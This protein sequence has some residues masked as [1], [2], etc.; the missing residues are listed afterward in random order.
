MHVRRLRVQNLRVHHDRTIDFT[1]TVTLIIGQ[2]GSGK[3][4][5]IEALYI[6]LRGKSFKGVDEMIRREGKDWY[7][8]DLETDE[9]MRI[10]KHQRDGTKKTF[11]IGGKTH[12]RLVDRVKYPIVLF[13]PDDLR[14]ISGSPARRRDYLDD[15][16]SQYD[17]HYMLVL[18]RYERA[19]LQRNKLLKQPYVTSDELFAWNVA[20]SRYGTDIIIARQELVAYI[21][22]RIT[23]VYQTIAPTDDQIAIHYTYRTSPSPQHLLTELEQVY[24]RDRAIGATTVGPHRQDFTI[25]FN[26]TPA[27][28]VGSRGELRTITLA[29]KFIEAARIIEATSLHPLILLDDVFSELDHT[30][31]ERLL[32][33]FQG[34]QVIMTSAYA[35]PSDITGLTLLDDRVSRRQITL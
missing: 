30:R 11:E 34:H 22:D 3:T 17:P 4:S 20:L 16:I 31:Q 14:I 1:D 8:I 27:S 2:N 29:L 24:E 32:S 21:N 26:D 33:E 15:V 35:N 23:E 13:E 19:L 6:A 5:L 28:S 7:R 12:Y 9:E 18:R 10:V 25:L